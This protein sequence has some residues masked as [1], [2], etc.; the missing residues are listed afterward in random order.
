MKDFRA[1]LRYLDEVIPLLYPP[2]PSFPADGASRDAAYAVVPSRFMPRRLVPRSRWLPWRRLLPQGP[3]TIEAHLSEV[4]GQRVRATSHI[5]P[6]RRANRKPVL[7]VRGASGKLLAFVKIGDSERSRELVR[8]ESATLRGLAATPLEVVVTPTVLHHAVWNGLEVLALSP[9]PAR[10]GRI[11]Q[12]L[13]NHAIHEIA[14]LGLPCTPPARLGHP[15]PYAGPGHYVPP[16]GADPHVRSA[17]PGDHV[18]TTGVGDQVLTTGVGDQVLTTGVGDQVPLAGHGG[19]SAYAWHGDFSPWNMAP[20]TD[21]RLLVWDWE[22]FAT[23]VPLGFDALHHFLQ[24]AL[25]RMSPSVAAEACLA[26]AVRTLAPFGLTAAKARET[27]VRYLIALADRH[28]GDGHQP[29]GPPS[30]WLNPLV[31]HQEVLP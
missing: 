21:G 18:L 2:Q 20:A 12:G 7:E 29:L 1:R 25:R 8:H 23:G 3:G 15:I 16:T 14:A 9:L 19:F 13:L 31:D 11:P 4:F 17:K 27:S 5:R 10:G 28:E 22:R 24:R 26:Q 6:A 30:E